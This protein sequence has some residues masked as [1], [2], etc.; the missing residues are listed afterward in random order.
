MTINYFIGGRVDQLILCWGPIWHRA[1]L[2]MIQLDRTNFEFNFERTFLN[3]LSVITLNPF[4]PERNG[5]EF[6][7]STMKQPSL[8]THIG[9]PYMTHLTLMGEMLNNLPIPTPFSMRYSIYAKIMSIATDSREL[10][11]Q[12]PLKNNNNIS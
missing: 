8:T 12:R 5:H 4:L 9:R 3:R 11:L 2:S 10:L 7:V 1:D 6:Q